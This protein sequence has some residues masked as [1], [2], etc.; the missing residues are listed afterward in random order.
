M[1]DK[2]RERLYLDALLRAC[3]GLASEPIEKQE[4]PDFVLGAPPCRIGIEITTFYLAPPTGERPYQEQHA[5]RERAVRQANRY[6]RA[7]GGPALYVSVYFNESRPLNKARIQSLA[8]D[9]S[10]AVASQ[11]DRLPVGEPTVSIPWD[12]L[13]PEVSQVEVLA[14][15]DGEDELWRTHWGGWVSSVQPSE[16]ERVIRRKSGR[17]G[18]ARRHCDRL[19]LVVVDDPF[20][21]GA[22]AAI[23]DATLG[24]H[25]EH[26]FDRVVWFRPHGGLLCDVGHAGP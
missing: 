6:Y 3:P 12:R 18:Q 5:L 10:A 13:P 19:W 4:P 24:H 21:G 20:L 7:A 2:E 22:P 9:I 1:P 16:L 26:T 25:Y 23:S 15:F 11:A 8:H 17:A 14:S